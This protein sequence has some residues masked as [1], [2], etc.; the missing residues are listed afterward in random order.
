M[1]AEKAL[2]KAKLQ[3]EKEWFERKSNFPYLIKKQ[4]LELIKKTDPLELAA[5]GSLT[6]ILQ[7]I[8]ATSSEIMGKIVTA[9]E[10]GVSAIEGFKVIWE[11]MGL[12]PPTEKQKEILD[13]PLSWVLAFVMAFIMVRHPEVI[14]V[15]FENITRLGLGLLG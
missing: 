15:T 1:K 8:V 6:I 3:A 9:T 2:T 14:V 5:V 7:P 12:L 4:L 10:H 13:A 11:W